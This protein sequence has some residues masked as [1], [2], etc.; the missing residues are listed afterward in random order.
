MRVFIFQE[1]SERKKLSCK[2]QTDMT[3]NIENRGLLLARTYITIK[4]QTAPRKD[5][6]MYI[7]NEPIFRIRGN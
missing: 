6:W 1:R 2:M 7:L 4:P 3:I 5:S